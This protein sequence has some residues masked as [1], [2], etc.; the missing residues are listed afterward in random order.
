MCDVAGLP[1]GEN[2]VHPGGRQA[3]RPTAN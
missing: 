2:P 3:R 1:P